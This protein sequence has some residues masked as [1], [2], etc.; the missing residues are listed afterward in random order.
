M[1]TRISIETAAYNDRRYGRPWIALVDFTE[2][3]GNFTFGDFV[4]SHG[5]A[6]LLEIEAHP[7]EIIAR[8]QKDNRQ[9]RNSAPTFHHVEEGGTLSA[10]MSKADA[11]KAWRANQARI[12]SAPR[13]EGCAVEDAHRAGPFAAFTDAEVL[14]EAQRRCLVPVSSPVASI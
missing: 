4:G 9:P 5:S 3:K 1:K 13:P 14:A 6:G 11:L 7:G 2:T 12:A 10:S 8:G